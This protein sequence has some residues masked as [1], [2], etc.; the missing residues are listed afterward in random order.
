MTRVN[1]TRALG[2]CFLN[3]VLSLDSHLFHLMAQRNEANEPFS[4]CTSHGNDIH[5]SQDTHRDCFAFSP[6]FLV[7]RHTIC[8]WANVTHSI[9]ISLT[10]PVKLNTFN[11]VILGS[12][13]S[14]LVCK[15]C[16]PQQGHYAQQISTILFVYFFESHWQFFW[17]QKENKRFVCHVYL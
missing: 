2:I 3:G 9:A 5:I 1:C 6:V 7:F 16:S 4:T 13:A 17:K 15:T 8:V 11:S 14:L 10:L 12:R